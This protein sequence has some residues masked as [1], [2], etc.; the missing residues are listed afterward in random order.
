MPVVRMVVVPAPESLPATLD[1][2]ML[3]A[4]LA[5]MPLSTTMLSMPAEV[6]NTPVLAGLNVLNP[7]AV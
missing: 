7:V 6:R 4:C 1:P 5:L 3:R 2:I